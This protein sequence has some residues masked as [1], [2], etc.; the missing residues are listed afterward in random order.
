MKKKI[1]LVL[2]LFLTIFPLNA[3]AQTKQ[4]KKEDYRSLNLLE[5]LESEEI[6][7]KFSNYQE[8]DDQITIYLFR[9]QGCDYCRKFLNYLNNITEEYGKYF[10]LESFEVWMDTKNSKLLKE[11]SEFLDESSTGVPYIIIGENVF[12]GYTEQYNDS[13]ENAIKEL[14]ESEDRYDLF[15]AMQE[16][17]ERQNKKDYSQTILIIAINFVMITASTIIILNFTNSKYKLLSEKIEKTNIKQDKT[18][19]KKTTK[20]IGK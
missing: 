5:T 15:K 1:L 19:V 3:S 20:K 8:N 2:A 17:Y 13:I 10:K 6:K 12:P 4:I 16:E 11:V 7:P 18:N 9:G 14:Y